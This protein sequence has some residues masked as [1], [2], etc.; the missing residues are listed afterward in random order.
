MNESLESDEQLRGK[1][2]F[3][4]A[5]LLGESHMR[6]RY[7][8][9][10]SLGL[11][12]YV[13]HELGFWNHGEGISGGGCT[14]VESPGRNLIGI[15]YD[16]DS[17]DTDR[18]LAVDGLSDQYEVR[19]IE[20]IDTECSM[21]PAYTLRIRSNNGAWTPPDDYARLIMNGAE[22][23]GLP[24]KYRNRLRAIIVGVHRT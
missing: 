5:T 10:R 15:L 21:V 19:Q 11:A 6:S 22:E 12:T 17:V 24:Q 16:L 20:V 1:P 14:I 8:S 4:Y 9:A 3:G 7:P 13:D 18:L 23:A 2:Y